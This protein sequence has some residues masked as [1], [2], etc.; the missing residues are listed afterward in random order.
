MGKRLIQ[1]RRG[2]GTGTYRS[3]G[4]RFKGKI[5]LP[6]TLKGQEG[7]V[8]DLIHCAGHSAPLMSV[9][10]DNKEQLLVPAPHGIKVGDTL[11]TGKGRVMIVKYLT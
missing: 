5:S 3:P 7:V 10:Y 6:K 4:H 11:S 8:L 9:I 1:Q 2:R